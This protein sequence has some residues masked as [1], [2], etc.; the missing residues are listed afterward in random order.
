M[1]KK[2]VVYFYF[3]FF[4]CLIKHILANDQQILKKFITNI[5]NSSHLSPF[6]ESLPYAIHHGENANALNKWPA[7]TLMDIYK[8]RD[9]TKRVSFKIDTCFP[10]YLQFWE[11]KNGM[12][13]DFKF[14][15]NGCNICNYSIIHS[16][17]IF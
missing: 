5:K 6:D 9:I 15:M 7:F 13:V 12:K 8:N 2:I 14:E 4:S 3:L 10:S 1:I 11:N 17:L 16:H